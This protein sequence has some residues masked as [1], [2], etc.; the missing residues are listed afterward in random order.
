VT[1]AAPPPPPPAGL[2]PQPAALA[3]VLALALVTR[4]HLRLTDPRDSRLADL[5]GGVYE[6]GA[7]AWTGSR[8]AFVGFYTPSADPSIAG[9]D[10]AARCA[11][12]ARWG[13]QRLAVQ[14]AER[15]DIL[16]VAMGPVPGA[17]TAPESRPGVHVGATA[18]DPATAA[19]TAL[20]PPP[21]DLPSAREIRAAQQALGE[22]R[23]AP[24][25][26]AVD[27]AERQTVAGGYAQPAR[28]Q[29][30]TTPVATYALIASFVVVFIIEKLLLRTQ[31]QLADQGLYD[32][33]ALTSPPTEWWRFVSSAFIHDPISGLSGFGAFPAHLIFNCLAMYIVG[34]LVEQL[35]GPL[36]LVATFVLAAVGGGLVW[37]AWN[38]LANQ[39]LGLSFGAS[40]G[41]T[42]LLGLL[43][44]LGR[45]QGK[46]VP[47]GLA[48]TMHGYV[49]RYAAMILLF[50]FLFA[51]TNNLAHI[52]GFIAGALV[53]VALPPLP[54]V[55][56]RPLASY[57]RVLLYAVLA[58]AAVALVLAAV[59]VTAQLGSSPGFTTAPA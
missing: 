43:L 57:E 55:G 10:L 27:L 11:A 17:L 58:T 39:P 21:P 42:G 23:E 29:L 13:E 32:L 46:N 5:G 25:L 1:E 44:M 37:V 14:G 51:G 59:N 50:G 16:I 33:G 53:G 28:R 15:A 56:G 7:A 6:L 48:S 20:L 30:S 8:A 31:V 38:A 24:T 18:V 47:V 45:F 54:H 3:R 4:Y 49:I 34:R 22:G 35:Y 26:A 52:G 2:P 41:I 9:P 19:V 36:V 40:G 12:A